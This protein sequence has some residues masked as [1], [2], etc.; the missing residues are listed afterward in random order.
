MSSTLL[1]DMPGKQAVCEA[2]KL[3]SDVAK[4]PRSAIVHV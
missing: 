4:L 1:I 2:A 3:S